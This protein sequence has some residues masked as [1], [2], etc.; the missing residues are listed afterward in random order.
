[1]SA[2]YCCSHMLRRHRRSSAATP[3]PPSSALLFLP[4]F[5]LGKVLKFAQRHIIDGRISCVNR[6]VSG[7]IVFSIAAAVARLVSGR[8]LMRRLSTANGSADGSGEQRS[9]YS[10]LCSECPNDPPCAITA[11]HGRRL[12]LSS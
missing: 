12:A 6:N 9:S 8:S 2:R 10:P 7:R 3:P 5:R 11:I 1:P 4:C